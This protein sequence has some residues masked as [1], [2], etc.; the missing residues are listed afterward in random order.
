MS[1]MRYVEDLRNKI[2]LISNMEQSGFIGQYYTKKKV[3]QDILKMSEEEI[4]EMNQQIMLEIQED[5][6]K[7]V[8]TM[9]LQAKLGLLPPEEQ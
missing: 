6:N 3:M 9:Q 1:E 5:M 8:F 4:E 7:Q 2:D